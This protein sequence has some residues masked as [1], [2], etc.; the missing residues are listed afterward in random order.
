MADQDHPSNDELIDQLA[1]GS[2]TLAQKMVEVATTVQL[3]DQAGQNGHLDYIRGILQAP[4]LVIDQ[5]EDLGGKLGVVTRHDERPAI[6]VVETERLALTE[7]GM[8][9]DMTIG[10][11]SESLAETDVDVKSDTEAEV[12]GGWIFGNAR[13]KTTLSA[14][15]RHKSR[16]TRRTDMTAEMSVT[17]HMRRL[18]TPEGLLKAIDAANEFSRMN[19]QLRL[20]ALQDKLRRADAAPAANAASNVSANASS[21]AANQ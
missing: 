16:N 9:F 1:R 14:E 18:P 15:V 20:R 7:V 21:N 5:T 3:A 8:E 19:N 12:S 2:G 10:S 11:H 4:N 13:V 17:M 6:S